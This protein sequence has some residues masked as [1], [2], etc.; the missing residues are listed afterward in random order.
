VVSRFR[1]HDEIEPSSIRA[2]RDRQ[3]VPSRCCAVNAVINACRTEDLLYSARLVAEVIARIVRA[4]DAV[5]DAA[6]I[7]MDESSQKRARVSSG[8]AALPPQQLDLAQRPNKYAYAR[9]SSATTSHRGQLLLRRDPRSL[10]LPWWRQPSTVR[11]G[12][13]VARA[14]AQSFQPDAINR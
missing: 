10:V 3:Q 13:P 4:I 7:R 6:A 2:P 12:I 1:S 8:D 14:I 9:S 11:R 5:E